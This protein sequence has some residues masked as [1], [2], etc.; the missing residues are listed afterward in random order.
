MV[1]GCYDLHVD[2]GGWREKIPLLE[3][4][5][6]HGVCFVKSFPGSDF[7]EFSD[8]ISGFRDMGG[9]DIITGALLTTDVQKNARKALKKADI[10]LVDGGDTKVNRLASE[11][12]EVDVL[13]NPEKDARKDFMKQKYSG[14]DHIMSKFMGERKIALEFSFSQVL[15]SYGMLRSQVMGRMRQNVVLARKYDVPVI[16]TSAGVE[17]E[18]LRSPRELVAFGKSLGMT[19]GEA[20][21]S[22]GVNPQLIIKKVRDRKDPNILMRGLEVIEWGRQKPR[23]DKRM[24]GI[25]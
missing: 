13:C 17:R 1:S 15:N 18:D 5:G 2:G 10:V 22:V 24:W 21:A 25:Y 11:C 9:M 19:G 20:R 6:W 23:K 12:F 14:I 4:L 3:R 16:I 8:E 7:R